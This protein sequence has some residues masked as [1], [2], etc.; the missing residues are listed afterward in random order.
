M[1]ISDWSSDVCSSDLASI[2]ALL[3]P[4]KR[5]A[6]VRVNDMTGVGGFVLPGDRV[7]VLITRTLPGEGDRTITDIL[8]QNIR[9]LGIEQQ[10]SENDDKPRSE[11]RRVGKEGDSTG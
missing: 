4:E 8:L 1:R 6:S 10:A 2:S 9:V 3:D 5:A 7:D 11:E